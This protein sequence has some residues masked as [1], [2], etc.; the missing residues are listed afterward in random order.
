MVETR[1]A[2][3]GHKRVLHFTSD[4]T[5]TESFRI[6]GMIITN[7]IG[8]KSSTGI[9]SAFR[10]LDKVQ[11]QALINKETP[12]TTSGPTIITIFVFSRRNIYFKV[13]N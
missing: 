4:I 13:R 11:R 8:K 12:N 9:F 7:Y 10:Q 3:C 5:M 1:N 6:T 2:H